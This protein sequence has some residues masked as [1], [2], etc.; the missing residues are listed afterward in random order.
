MKRSFGFVAGPSSAS[1]EHREPDLSTSE[2]TTEHSRQHGA[3]ATM[4]EVARRTMS[5]RDGKRS[6]VSIV[7]DRVV[8]TADLERAPTRQ[9][10]AALDRRRSAIAALSAEN[11]WPAWLTRNVG[12]ERALEVVELVGETKL[13]QLMHTPKHERRAALERLLRKTDHAEH[14]EE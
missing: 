9:E 5:A 11:Q 7:G 4:S 13:R 14:G 6:D 8:H 1:R 10:Q 12:A 3:I 2:G